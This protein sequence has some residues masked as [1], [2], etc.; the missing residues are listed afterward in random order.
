MNNS[1]S[2]D[3]LS[4]FRLITRN[5]FSASWYRLG[6]TGFGFEIIQHKR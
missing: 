6:K 2:E 5:S 3:D 4:I 1:V